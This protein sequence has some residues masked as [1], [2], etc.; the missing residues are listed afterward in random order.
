[1]VLFF[2]L[3]IDFAAVIFMIVK[4]ELFTKLL[5]TALSIISIVFGGILTIGLGSMII[6]AWFAD[7]LDYS[8]TNYGPILWTWLFCFSLII[9]SIVLLIKTSRR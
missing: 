5:P 4:N 3:I 8:H 1:M 6:L 7:Q 2:F 9:S